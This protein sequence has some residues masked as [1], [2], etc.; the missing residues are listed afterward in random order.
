MDIARATLALEAAN[1]GTWK[2][3]TT[4]GE[5]DWDGPLERIFGLEPG[6]FPG[7]FEAY[8]ELLHP[9]DREATLH[10]I[11]EALVNKIDHY[12]EHRVVLEDGSIRWISGKGRV[13]LDDEGEP[14]GMVGIGED[15]TRR[16]LAEQRLEFLA[17]AGDVLGSSLD[18]GTTLQQLSDLVIEQLADWC[19]IDLIGED[20][21]ELVAVAHRDPGKVRYARGLRE[22]FGVD[23]DADVGLPMVLKTGTPYVLPEIDQSWLRGA[24]EQVPEITPKEIEEFMALELRSSMAVPLKTTDGRILGAL[25]LV[26]AESGR[27]YTDDDLTL[28]TEVARRASIAVENAQLFERT[29]YTART[30]QQSLMP[31]AIPD[32]GFA[33]IAT[34]FSPFGAAEE[35]IG[36]D[37]YDIF[38]LSEDTWCVVLGDVSGKGVGAVTLASASRW[39]FRSA[40]A[41]EPDPAGALEDLNEILAGQEWGNRFVTVV[42]AVLQRRPD[43]CVD[44]RCSTG[45][46]PSPAIRRHDGTAE[47]MVIKGT[48]IGALPTGSWCTERV[49]LE[50]GD[51]LVLYSDG[52]TETSN[53]DGEFFGESRVLSALMDKDPAVDNTAKGLLDRI[54]DAARTF[55][56]QRDDLAIMVV[57][58]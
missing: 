1:A 14:K 37:F 31:P 12:V 18:L 53:S 41:H 24:L 15:I 52:L 25:S 54:D 9:D 58:C 21:V 44:V 6:T 33:E 10:T 4:T 45:G 39:T 17:R 35:L 32:V 43:G 3:I 13:V 2:W 23:M 50:P 42:A 48:L 51:A 30:L 29:Q 5:L 22:R 19:S 38:Q 27:R 46:H 57:G 56:Q 26:A 20:G 11:R 36:G 49:V 47:S 28:A 34:L 55:G 40:V 7:T 16:R 8:I